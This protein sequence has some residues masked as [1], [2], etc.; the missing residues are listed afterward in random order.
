MCLYVFVLCLCI[1]FVFMFV[2]VLFF[3]CFVCFLFIFKS[4]CVCSVYVCAHVCLVA[5]PSAVRKD[6]EG[7]ALQEVFQCFS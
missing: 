5:R 6:E 4:F 2:F 3:V 1:C 7:E